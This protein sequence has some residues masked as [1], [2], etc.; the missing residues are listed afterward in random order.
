MWCCAWWVPLAST[1]QGSLE[2]KA[3]TWGGWGEPSGNQTPEN[4][5]KHFSEE[6]FL[7]LLGEGLIQ[8][9]MLEL[10][11]GYPED[12]IILLYICVTVRQMD[13]MGEKKQKTVLQKYHVVVH[14]LRVSLLMGIKTAK[15]KVPHLLIFFFTC[16]LSGCAWIKNRKILLFMDS[17]S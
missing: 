9:H 15:K 6:S 12:T 3:A 4:N 8:Q 16:C 14:F 10:H 1:V 11:Y 7:Q 5:I 13:C 2:Y 17:T